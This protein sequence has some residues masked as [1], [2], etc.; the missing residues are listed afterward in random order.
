M[1]INEVLFNALKYLHMNNSSFDESMT[2]HYH[3]FP[4]S[5]NTKIWLLPK[6]SLNDKVHGSIKAVSPHVAFNKEAFQLNKMRR[7]SKIK[8]T[9]VILTNP[10]IFERGFTVPG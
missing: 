4:N 1:K 3:K 7:E 2:C 5:P 8:Q 10:V 9:T 6:M